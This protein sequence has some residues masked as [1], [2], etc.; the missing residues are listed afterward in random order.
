MRGAGALAV[1]GLLVAGCAGGTAAPSASPSASLSPGPSPSAGPSLPA[2]PG[3]AA[4]AVRLRTDEAVGGQLQVRVTDTGTTPFTVTSVTIESP[5]FGPLPATAL[6]ADFAP[7]RTIDL[8]TPYG[9]VVCAAAPEPAAARLTVVRPGGVAEEVR[10][11][12]DG[13]MLAR[14]HREECAVE[15]LLEV[16]GVDVTELAPTPD[17]SGLAGA[18]VLTRRTGDEPVEVTAL[19][20]NVLLE[21]SLEEELPARLAAG[22]DELRLP[23]TFGVVTCSAHVLAEV[24][25]P[26]VFP[27]SVVVGEAEPVP[28]DLPLDDAQKGALRALVDRV[29]V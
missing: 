4:E 29:C 9:P 15:A 26:F 12:L 11:P 3:M 13:G 7:G 14:V 2:V 1:A 6:T 17:G 22:E 5:R 16:V 19:A 28:V 10:V 25:Q 21:P 18:V 8:T 27:L 20:R 24:K 23:V